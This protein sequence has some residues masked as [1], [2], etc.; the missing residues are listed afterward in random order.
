MEYGAE[1]KHRYYDGG[2]GTEAQANWLE[3]DQLLSG[4][5]TLAEIPE[6]A[7][8]ALVQLAALHAMIAEEQPV[9][10]SVGLDGIASLT[11]AIE[12][13]ASAARDCFRDSAAWLRCS[14]ICRGDGF[15][16]SP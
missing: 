6:I 5:P 10:N 7:D 15:P 1:F 12:N 14:Q 8:K 2:A 11:K 4:I 9:T 13:A 3:I 16:F